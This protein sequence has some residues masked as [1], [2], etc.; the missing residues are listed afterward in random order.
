MV[1][2]KKQFKVMAGEILRPYAINTGST[3]SGTTQVGDI[4]IGENDT[5]DYSTRPGGVTWYMG[6]DENLGYLIVHPDYENN[7]PRFKRTSGFNDDLFLIK[8]NE[9]ASIMGH[10]SF[11]GLTDATNWL[12][13]SGYP[14]MPSLDITFDSIANVPVASATNVSDWNTFFDLPTNGTPFTFVSV[15]DNTVKLYGGKNIKIEDYLFLQDAHLVE[16]DDY[17][18]IETL[19]IDCFYKTAKLV[20]VTMRGVITSLATSNDYGPFGESQAL[21]TLRLPRLIN[22]GGSLA[23]MCTKLTEVDLSSVE[24][25]GDYGLYYCVSLKEGIF[26]NLKKFGYCSFY[27]VRFE[28]LDIPRVTAET[29]SEFYL[30]S[31]SSIEGVPRIDVTCDPSILTYNNGKP[32][33]DLLALALLNDVYFNGVLYDPV[34]EKSSGDL[35]ISFDT[36]TGIETAFEGRMTDKDD[37]N[38]WNSIIADRAWST[39]FTSLEWEGTTIT[40][41]G[42]QNICWRKHDS[43]DQTGWELTHMTKFEDHGCVISVGTYALYYLLQNFVLPAVRVTGEWIFQDFTRTTPVILPELQIAGLA[44]FYGAAFSELYLPKMEYAGQSAFG[45][46]PGVNVIF[47]PFVITFGTRNTSS[48]MFYQVAGATITIT[49]PVALMTCNDGNPHASIAALQA[50]N[51]VTV[52]AYPSPLEMTLTAGGTGAG[53]AILNLEASE[54]TTIAL[55]GEGRFYDDAAGTQNPT[56][57]RTIV[58]GA[59]RAFYV[60]V[61][62]GESKL[63]INDPDLIIKWGNPDYENKWAGWVDGYYNDANGPVLSGAFDKLLNI[64]RISVGLYSAVQPVISYHMARMSPT[65]EEFEFSSLGTSVGDPEFMPRT[66]KYIYTF[67]DFTAGGDFANLPPIMEYFY[68]MTYMGYVNPTTVGVLGKFGLNLINFA[69]NGEQN[70]SGDFANVPEGWFG[71]NLGS[72]LDTCGGDFADLPNS[73][74]QVT[75]YGIGTISY[76]GGRTWSNDLNWVKIK[77]SGADGLSVQEQ[78]DLI[79]DMSKSAWNRGRDNSYFYIRGTNTVSMADTTQGGIWGDFSGVPAPTALATALKNLNTKINSAS[80]LLKDAVVPGITGDGTGFP[81]GFGN[82]WRS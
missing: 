58:A 31:F 37:V 49:I 63:T 65:L 81:A 66:L 75:Y 46:M 14:I 71:F 62:S 74:S 29:V 36:L 47:M 32:H 26:P 18:C 22:A 33:P 69:P 70:V 68:Q 40:L 61:A 5:Y 23:Y 57:Q 50:A 3:I 13:L 59:M 8:A 4:A 20:S 77:P 6:P 56:T 38:V 21:T 9:V 19:G 12:I 78:S 25:V 72:M 54:D 2:I 44:T 1:F 30:T 10:E 7:R 45:T 82:W 39:P 17:G 80:I 79:I 15:D 52:V 55:D 11:T 35:I 64:T 41:K 48:A 60:K 24:D 76:T 28:V 42:G 51:T 43:W 27:G 67:C 16:I 34:P 73:I 53:V